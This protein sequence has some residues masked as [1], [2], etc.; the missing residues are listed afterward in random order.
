MIKNTFKI[1]FFLL[2]SG[3]FFYSCEEDEIDIVRVQ[4]S[5][6][7]TDPSSFGAADGRINSLVDGGTP[8]Y[9]YFWSNGE[10]IENISGLTAGEYTLNVIDSRSAVGSQTV[11][12]IQPDATPLD[13]QFTV[14]E[15]S[16]FGESDGAINLT[17]SG[18][19]APYTYIWNNGEESESLEGLSTGMYAVT[20]TDSGD[21]SIITSDSVFVAEPEFVCGRDS[22]IDV[23]GNKYP[24]VQIG[25][26]CWTA[27][28]L[29]TTHLPKD[30]LVEIA[31]HFCLGTNCSNANGAHYT[32]E[33][34]MNGSES[35]DEDE[36]S[37]QGICPCE[38]HIP[39]KA[40]WT[41]LNSYLSVNGNG[42]SG[43]NVPNKLRGTD[44][45]SGFNALLVGNFGYDLFNGEL[46]AFWTATEQD[47]GDAIYRI[48][49]N[50]PLLGQGQ[51]DKRNGL[52]VRCVKD[53]D[54]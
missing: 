2:L 20:V 26:Q 19:M 53:K 50:F 39:S 31:G 10:T 3:L 28:N 15:V 29:R 24:T 32:W 18:G 27:E 40:E 16:R 23:D 11:V 21:P 7:A 43:Q 1:F 25:D 38:W 8:P 30:P 41:T 47:E 5:L 42:G 54:Q 6:E 22:I 49:N 12:L 45:S 35:T 4:I 46:A 9:S 36:E 37:V 51:T 44:S 34:A 48:I 33:A 13:L 14:T 52:S 17:I